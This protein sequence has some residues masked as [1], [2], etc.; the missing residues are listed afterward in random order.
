MKEQIIL[1]YP[2]Q[3]KGAPFRLVYKPDKPIPLEA[4]ES[5]LR[6]SFNQNGSNHYDLSD[7]YNVIDHAVAELGGSWN[8]LEYDATVWL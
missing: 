1:V 5:A 4:F 6:A 7:Y 8:L 3:G 2:P